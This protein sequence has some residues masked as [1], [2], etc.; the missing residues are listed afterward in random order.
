MQTLEIRHTDYNQVLYSGIFKNIKECVEQAIKE[1]V[2]LE[3]VNL[4]GAN[5]EGANLEGAYL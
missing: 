3:G 2:N 1:G 4:E 5:L